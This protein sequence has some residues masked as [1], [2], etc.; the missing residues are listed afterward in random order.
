MIDGLR[1]SSVLRFTYKG[2]APFYDLLVPL[3]SSRARSLGRTWLDVTDGDAVLDLGTGTGLALRPLAG[4]T[5][6]GWT[7]GVDTSPAMLERA[8]L[9]MSTCSHRRYGLRRAPA[10]ALPYP[11]DAFDAVFSAYLIDVLPLPKRRPVLREVRRVLRPAG[12]AVLVYLAPPQ[13]SVEQAWA[14]LART[15]PPL[16]GGGRP[17]SLLPSLR[18]SELDVLRHTTRVQAGLRSGI[19]CVAPA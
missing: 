1:S 14:H 6:H 16:L 17:L 13:T 3:L 9:R 15:M 2:L 12:R 10:T 11:D 7:E 8:R 18:K 4:A 19:T 5:P